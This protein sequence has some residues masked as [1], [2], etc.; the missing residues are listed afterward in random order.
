MNTNAQPFPTKTRS[1]VIDTFAQQQQEIRVLKGL[2]ILL[3]LTAAYEFGPGI[4]AEYAIS[5]IEIREPEQQTASKPL[6][7][8]RVQRVINELNRLET[9]FPI[10]R[11][12]IRPEKAALEAIR[13]IQ[14]AKMTASQREKILVEHLEKLWTFFSQPT[15]ED[16]SLFEP[17]K[18]EIQAIMILLKRKLPETAD[19]P[20]LPSGDVRISYIELAGRDVFSYG[21][22]GGEK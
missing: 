10:V 17:A 19:L 20:P 4:V 13:E 21:T 6:P 5:G 1:E 11:S 3:F 18:R 15:W 14:P 7:P 9:S 22:E 12:S 2:L 8:K 16:A